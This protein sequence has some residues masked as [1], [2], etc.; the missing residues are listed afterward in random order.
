M[1]FIK[2]TFMLRKPMKLFLTRYPAFF[3][4]FCSLSYLV[5]RIMRKVVLPL[6]MLAI[7]AATADAKPRPKVSHEFSQSNY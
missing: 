1:F 2:M 7:L 3:R 5:G 6:L 4:I